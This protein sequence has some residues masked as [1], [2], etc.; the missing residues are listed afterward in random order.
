RPPHRRTRP[1]N[2]CG[3]SPGCG[4]CRLGDTCLDTKLASG[5]PAPVRYERSAGVGRGSSRVT[6][7]A[8]SSALLKRYVD[9]PASDAAEELLRSDAE[10][11]TG[12]HTLVEVRRNLARIL[13]GT[14]LTEARG[15]FA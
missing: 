8:D 10:L 5:A 12:R 13:S 4:R 9:E 7:Y 3:R 14:A 2:R 1:G 15:W 6:S 11:V